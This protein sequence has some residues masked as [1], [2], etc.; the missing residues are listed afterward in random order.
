MGRRGRS[1]GDSIRGMSRAS[2]RKKAAVDV[3]RAVRSGDDVV[4]E[5]GVSSAPRAW[6]GVPSMRVR[7][8]WTALSL[9]A[10]V[11]WFLGCPDFD[12]WPL[13][14]VA[15]VPVLFAVER[16]A[17]VRGAFVYAWLTG[18]VGNLGGFYWLVGLLVRF[19]NFPWIGALLSLLVICAYQGLVF[20]LTGAVVRRVRMHVDLPMAVVAPVSM[21]TFEKLLPVVFPFYVAITQAWQAHVIQ[22]ADLTGPL[23]VT[24]LLL[25]VNGAIYDVLAGGRR[26][27]GAAI[28][29]GLVLAAALIYGRWRIEQV[30]RLRASAPKIAVGVVQPNVPFHMKGN[31]RLRFAADQLRAL[32][33]QSSLLQAEGAE[34]IVWPESSYPY[35]L[36]R[37]VSRDF[38]EGSR[39]RIQRGFDVPVVVGAITKEPGSSENSGFYNSAVMVDRDGRFT[40]RF[41]KRFL[42]IMGEYTPGREWFPWITRYMPEAAG[43][44]ERGQSVITL[45]LRTRDGKEYRLGPMICYEDILTE[46]GRQLA[47]LRPHLLVNITNDAWF[48]DTSE[49]WEHLAL[50]VFRAVELRTDL[51]RAVNTGVSAFID[52]AGRVTA[53]TYSVDPDRDPRGAD[54]LLHRVALIEGGRTVYAIV[55]DLFAWMCVTATAVLYVLPRLRRRKGP[56]S[57]TKG[58]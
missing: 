39:L 13:S 35:I 49:P 26:R 21:V 27:W 50:S 33:E 42:L 14:W 19:A 9:L 46:F 58:A 8:G 12:L 57:D 54:R 45:P 29:A 30:E 31:D 48:G 11:L 1:R 40:A 32:Q 52:A 28:G 23:G 22:V 41:D 10:G 2:V 4:A 47:R 16:A 3:P 37:N 53:R 55:G 7:L 38:S 15:M 5:G 34:L 17:T 25:M 24:A 44:L 20:G 51:V 43:Q 36:L 6:V 18:I 56:V